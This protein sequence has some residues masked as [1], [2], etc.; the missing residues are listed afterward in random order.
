[1]PEIPNNFPQTK[2]SGKYYKIEV[3]KDGSWVDAERN[4]Q[5]DCGWLVKD[6]V[7]GDQTE[8]VMLDL[9]LHHGIAVSD[10][11]VVEEPSN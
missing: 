3:K 6:G 8:F 5:K 1:M 7:G 11:R 9:K 10:M 2:F 4:G